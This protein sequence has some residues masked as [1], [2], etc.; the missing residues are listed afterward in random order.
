MSQSELSVVN[1]ST[2]TSDQAFDSLTPSESG[3]SVSENSG[4]P[5]RSKIAKPSS[6][7]LSSASTPSRISRPCSQAPKPSLPPLPTRTSKFIKLIFCC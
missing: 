1:E 6:L 3:S 4:A 5:I 2:E 7:K